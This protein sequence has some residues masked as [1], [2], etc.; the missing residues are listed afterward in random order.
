MKRFALPTLVLLL[1]GSAAAAQQAVPGATAI[2]RWDANRDGRVTLAEV[3]AGRAGQFASL[4]RNGDG[5]L[6]V[7]EL[8]RNSPQ[9][10]RGVQRYALD[11]NG[12]GVVS[13]SEYVAGSKSWLQRMDSDSNGVLT[14]ADFG[15]RG[16]GNGRGNGQGYRW[17]NG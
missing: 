6:S 17:N 5:V 14:T 12:D 16:G 7:A 1:A 11:G 15:R 2:D 10:S 8:G 4:D 9:G 3:E 13:R